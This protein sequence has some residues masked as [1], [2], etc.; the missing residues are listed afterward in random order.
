[1]KSFLTF[2]SFCNS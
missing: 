2:C 1:M